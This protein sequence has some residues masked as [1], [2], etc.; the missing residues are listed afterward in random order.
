MFVSAIG[1]NYLVWVGIVPFWSAL[2]WTIYTIGAFAAVFIFIRLGFNVAYADPSLTVLQMVIALASGVWAYAIAGPGRGAVFPTPIVTLMF[3]MYALPPVAVR[4][5]G[6][7]AVALF[8][9]VMAT[10]SVLKPEVYEPKVEVMHCF[11]LSA[12]LM[13]VSM[14]ASQLSRLRQRL[15]AQKAELAEAL[16]RIQNLATHDELTGL[17]NRRYMLDL[18]QLEHQRCMRSGHPFCIVMLD[19]DHFKQINDTHGHP[20]GDAVLRAFADEVRSVM[21]AS[22][23]I[24]RWGGEEFLLLMTETRGSLGKPAIERLREHIAALRPKGVDS[25]LQITISAGLTEHRAGEP[26]SETISRADKAVYVAKSQGR[27]RVASL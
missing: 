26:V 19:L 3:G 18:L 24:A 5:M 21:R 11:V 16:H 8:G 6:W 27:N 10:M 23:T 2:W 9:A 22:D 20:A 13:V 15:R 7:L 1:V 25:S 17:Y 14:L 4:R 12:M